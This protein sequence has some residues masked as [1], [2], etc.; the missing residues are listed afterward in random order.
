MPAGYIDPKALQRILKMMRSLDA[1][2]K[3]RVFIS[4]FHKDD[5]RYRNRFEDL[6]GELFQNLSVKPGEINDDNSDGYIAQI[7]R[8][9]KISEATVLVV[10]VGNRT[11]CR[12]HVD[13]EI[14]AALDPRVGDRKAGLVGVILPTCSLFNTNIYAKIMEFYET[15]K[16]RITAKR[17]ICEAANE[18][19][20]AIC[21]VFE[22]KLPPRLL[23]NILSGYAKLYHWT[24]DKDEMFRI[25][26]E[27][28]EKRDHPELITNVRLKYSRNICGD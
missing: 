11:Y 5:E 10:L 20:D 22:T 4:Y 8:Q 24:E 7:I 28:F 9:N 3:R 15:M 23:D 16:G 14:A 26:N 6:F 21:K 13:W 1:A 12:K 2:R 25:I 19:N 27:A 18:I 17:E